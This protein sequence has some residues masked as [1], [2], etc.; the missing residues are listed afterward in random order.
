MRFS[1]FV[2]IKYDSLPIITCYHPVHKFLVPKCYYFGIFLSTHSVRGGNISAGINFNEAGIAS[3][4]R[5]KCS[6]LKVPTY[7]SIMHLL[8]WYSP[9]HTTVLLESRPILWNIIS[10]SFKQGVCKD[11]YNPNRTLRRNRLRPSEQ[12]C[13][14]LLKRKHV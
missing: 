11:K 9:K 2:S 10:G 14:V 7:H 8:P 12:V 5:Q 3:F 1:T 13:K 4:A 6:N